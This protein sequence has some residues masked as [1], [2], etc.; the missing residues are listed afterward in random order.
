MAKYAIFYTKN[1]KQSWVLGDRGVIR[2]DGRESFSTHHSIAKEW[3]K[4][5]GF[6]Y[7]SF[8]HGENVLRLSETGLMPV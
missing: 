4:K 1:D 8:G 3:A 6:K 7:Y 5:H 2:L